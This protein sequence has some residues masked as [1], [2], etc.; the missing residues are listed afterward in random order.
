MPVRRRFLGM[1]LAAVKVAA[2]HDGSE[3]P[4]VVR[5]RDGIGG[6]DIGIHRIG[7]GEVDVRALG[8]TLEQ[9]M[10]RPGMRQMDLVPAH[11]RHLEA[12]RGQNGARAVQQSQTPHPTA[13][14]G[15]EDRARGKA[16]PVRIG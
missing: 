10:P 3:V 9:R 12:P 1:E 8:E 2:A 13:A 6:I 14:L 11:V 7:M 4:G 5:Q 15:L 16:R